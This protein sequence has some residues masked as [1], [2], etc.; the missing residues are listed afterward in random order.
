[1]AINIQE[2]RVIANLVKDKT[3]LNK[4][5]RSLKIEINDED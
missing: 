3:G 4:V 1:M 2:D 5:I